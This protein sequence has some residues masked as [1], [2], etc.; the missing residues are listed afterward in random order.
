[1]QVVKDILRCYLAESLPDIL[2]I[3]WSQLLERFLGSKM[4]QKFRSGYPWGCPSQ[5]SLCDTTFWFSISKTTATTGMSPPN[6]E[7]A[8]ASTDLVTNWGFSCFTIQGGRS[9][10]QG[11]GEVVESGCRRGLSVG[12]EKVDSIMQSHEPS[13][14]FIATKD[15]RTWV[16]PQFGG[17][18]LCIKWKNVPS[19]QSIK[20]T[21]ASP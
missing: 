14:D 2:F 1:M 21:A 12:G 9:A 11:G 15:F 7:G 19:A 10:V 17:P 4:G 18:S 5:P 6:L 13:P 3:S 20:S 8:I 16:R